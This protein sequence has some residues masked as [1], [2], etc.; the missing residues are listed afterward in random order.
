MSP[1]HPARRGRDEAATDYR[2]PLS[3]TDWWFVAHPRSLSPVIQTVIEG[4]GDLGLAELTA[5]VA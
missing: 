1:Q 5:A 2:R 4:D 3:A